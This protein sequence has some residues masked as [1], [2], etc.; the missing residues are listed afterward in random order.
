MY[1]LLINQWTNPAVVVG[2][3]DKEEKRWASEVQISG[4]VCFLDVLL[5]IAGIISIICDCMV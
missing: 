2:G 4:A 3:L 5:S 1:K